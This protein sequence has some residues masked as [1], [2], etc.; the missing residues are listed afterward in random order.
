VS[1]P[2]LLPD[3]TGALVAGG[4]A[5]RLGGVAKGLLR[6]GGEAIAGRTVRLFADLFAASLVVANEPGPYAGLGAP[7]ISDAV[8][9][10]GAP[11]GLHAALAA[12]RTGWVFTAGCDMPF[13]S[14]GPIEWLAARRSAPAVA[15][16]WRG[17]LEPL[18]AFWSRECL[19]LV[20]RMIRSGDP[21]MWKIATACGARFV[22]EAEWREVDPDGRAFENANTPEDVV[23]LGL[24]GPGEAGSPS[25]RDR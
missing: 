4:Q 5:T 12:S 22:G 16:I 24:A 15:V 14:R 9:G 23:R 19:P 21:S 6:V 18:H 17:R 7:V 1:R 10:K 3:C 2:P 20:E 11:G 25:P 13:L 8:P